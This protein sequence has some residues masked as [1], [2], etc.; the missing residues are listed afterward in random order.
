MVDAEHLFPIQLVTFMKK[1]GYNVEA[2]NIG[3]ICTWR[4]ASDECGL[5]SLTRSK[6][7]YCPLNMI[8]DE[9]MPW[10][11]KSYNLH[12]WKSTGMYFET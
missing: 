5:S 9:L 6:Y 2:T 12:C 3:T 10:H 11:R 7:N 4:R 1:K 8:L